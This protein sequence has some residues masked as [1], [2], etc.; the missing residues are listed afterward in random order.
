MK[1]DPFGDGTA[2]AP[3]DGFDVEHHGDE[4]RVH[5]EVSVI[6]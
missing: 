1:P 6:K 4:Y 3:L 5:F 2:Y